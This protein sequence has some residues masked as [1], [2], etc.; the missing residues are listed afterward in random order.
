MIQI[1]KTGKKV[2]NNPSTLTHDNQKEKTTE[3][4][5]NKYIV[6]YLCGS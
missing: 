6:N 1:S 3:Y 2:V 5:T 4:S